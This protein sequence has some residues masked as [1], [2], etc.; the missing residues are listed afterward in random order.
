MTAKQQ[1]LTE[2]ANAIIPII[3]TASVKRRVI[4]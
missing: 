4:S 3:R 1:R 2:A